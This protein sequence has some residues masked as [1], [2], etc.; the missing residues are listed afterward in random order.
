MTVRASHTSNR[1]PISAER[2]S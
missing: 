1:L 2:D